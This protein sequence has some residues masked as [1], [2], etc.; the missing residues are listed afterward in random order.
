MI[1]A[2]PLLV[3]LI[4]VLSLVPIFALRDVKK[5][6]LPT[7]TEEKPSLESI[8]IGFSKIFQN[9]PPKETKVSDLKVLAIASGQA[10]LALVSEGRDVQILKV[11]QKIREYKVVDIRRNSIV[12]ERDGSREI[13]SYPVEPLSQET[14]VIPSKRFEFSKREIERLTNDP[15]VLFQ[16]IR[17][18][19]VIEAGKT[20]GFAFDWI[21]QGSI[22]EKA[23]IRQGD[24][25]VSINN[26]EIKSGEDAFRI[27]QAL[28]NEP[29][30]RVT[31]LRD[32]QNI[33]INL[34]IE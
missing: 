33:D 26:I 13:L 4:L 18:R 2:L 15:G 19:P 17:L 16:E 10:K 7:I 14:K 30:L 1:H 9:N 5:V 8:K 12:L 31:L 34:R 3:S 11:G 24:I 6:S 23:G 32:G 21:K 28:R 29:S 27:L 25:L 20:K 22:F